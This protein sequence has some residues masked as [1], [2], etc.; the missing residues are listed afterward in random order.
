MPETLETIDTDLFCR[1]CG[2]NLRGST[3]DRCPE[4]GTVFDR[5]ALRQ[6]T[7]PWLH[8]RS[9]GRWRAY[10]RTVWM[11]MRRPTAVGRQVTMPVLYAETIGFRRLTVAILTL[12]LSGGL[13][14]ALLLSNEIDE[15]GIAITQLWPSALRAFSVPQA[16]LLD[17]MLPVAAGWI[18]WPL[19]A[20]LYVWLALTG[21]TGAVTGWFHPRRLDVTH[22]NRAVAIANLASASLALLPIATAIFAGAVGLWSMAEQSRDAQHLWGGGAIL[23]GC[24]GIG[25]AVYAV[26][27][28]YVATL[29]LLVATGAARGGRL[30]LAAVLVP[31]QCAFVATLALVALPWVVGFFSLVVASLRP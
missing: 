8:R 1:I 31:L 4:C 25:L 14:A 11:I 20:P 18:Q 26:A 15:F 7:I 13:V 10:W 28:A 19:I 5:T 2:Y 23:I 30:W 6:A 9:L 16:A 21:A 22:Q 27:F 3:G 29:Y 24:V 17:L 12:L